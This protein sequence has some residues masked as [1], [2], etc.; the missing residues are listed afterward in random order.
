[1]FLANELPAFVDRSNGLWDRVIVLPFNK[2]F[3]DTDAEKANLKYDLEAELSGIFNWAV[4]G[5]RMLQPLKRFPVLS[6]SAAYLKKHRNA[7]DHEAAFLKE[8]VIEVPG[9]KCARQDLY[10]QY[11]F[12]VERH[13][14]KALGMDRFNSAVK[15]AFPEVKEGRIRKPF[16]RLAWVGIDFGHASYTDETEEAEGENA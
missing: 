3:R 6:A 7:C 16:D 8:S 13:G 4:E 10:D 9:K 5:A 2:R 14:Y 15:V 12:W 1:M 11:R